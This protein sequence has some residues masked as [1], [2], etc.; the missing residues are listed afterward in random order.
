MDV[1]ALAVSIVALLLSVVAYWRAGGW[2][3]LICVRK[4]LRDEI[5]VLRNKQRQLVDSVRQSIRHT[6][7]DLTERIDRAEQ[8]LVLM[9]DVMVDGIEMPIRL[10]IE[11]LKAARDCI[12]DRTAKM[13]DVAVDASRRAQQSVV[14]HVHRL[15]ARVAMLGAEADTF[16]ARRLA[17]DT[18]FEK[19]EELMHDALAKVR[20]AEKLLQNDHVFDDAIRQLLDSIREALT[21]V[22]TNADD[23]RQRLDKVM[24]ESESLVAELAQA[25]RQVSPPTDG[26]PGAKELVGS[27]T[28]N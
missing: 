12:Q 8:R 14:Q 18:E 10:A 22:R 15:E 25:E 7:D 6:Y 3:D 27:G 20:D 19:A 9:K 17:N 13:E 5:D 21:A 24:A 23:A 16:R 1:I 26:Q 2:A 4:E 11:Q 28:S